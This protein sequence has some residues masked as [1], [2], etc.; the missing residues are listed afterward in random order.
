MP[1]Y[2]DKDFNPAQPV[3]NDGLV[4]WIAD[5]SEASLDLDSY[6][7]LAR[8][9]RAVLALELNA[10]S[11]LFEQWPQLSAEPKDLLTKV[12]LDPATRSALDSLFASPSNTRQPCIKLLQQFR[13]E[14]AKRINYAEVYRHLKGQQHPK[15]LEEC[16]RFQARIQEIRTATA[17]HTSEALRQLYRREYQRIEKERG[18]VMRG[19]H[20]IRYFDTTRQ[21][22]LTLLQVISPDAQPQSQLTDNDIQ[23]LLRQAL[24][25]SN[26]LL[27]NQIITAEKHYLLASETAQNLAAQLA[28]GQVADRPCFAVSWGDRA[29][30][31][32]A[33]GDVTYQEIN[34]HFRLS[35]N[36]TIVPPTEQSVEFNESNLDLHALNHC[37]RLRRLS[38]RGTYQNTDQDQQERLQLT[39]LERAALQPNSR[40]NRLTFKWFTEKAYALLRRVR[41]SVWPNNPPIEALNSVMENSLPNTTSLQ[42]GLENHEFLNILSDA[43]QQVIAQLIA[44]EKVYAENLPLQPATELQQKTAGILAFGEEALSLRNFIAVTDDN[45]AYITQTHGPI[46]LALINRHLFASDLSGHVFAKETLAGLRERTGT[47]NG[48]LNPITQN[49]LS[50]TPIG[51]RHLS[52]TKLNQLL[53]LRRLHEHSHLANSQ[54]R[55]MITTLPPFMQALLEMA[56]PNQLLKSSWFNPVA[57]TILQT[58]KPLNSLTP[59]NI[60]HL[61]NLIRQLN[62][63]PDEVL[64]NNI[65]LRQELTRLNLLPLQRQVIEQLLEAEKAYTVNLS[66]QSPQRISGILAFNQD[67]IWMRDFIAVTDKADEAD[68][69][70]PY[71]TKT[72]GDV[73]LQEINQCLFISGAGHVYSR[74][75]QENLPHQRQNRSVILDPQ[76]RQPLN[77]TDIN[78]Q[79]L[80]LAKL[81]QLLQLRRLHEQPTLNDTEILQT[82]NSLPAFMQDLLRTHTTLKASWF[83]GAAYIKLQSM[84]HLTLEQI[85]RMNAVPDQELS[86]ADSIE[87]ALARITSLEPPATTLSSEPPAVPEQIAPQMGAVPDQEL[88]NA[89]NGGQVLAPIPL[90]P[91]ALAADTAIT[92]LTDPIPV[93]VLSSAQQLAT[94]YQAFVQSLSPTKKTEAPVSTWDPTDD[95]TARHNRLAQCLAFCLNYLPQ[96]I[97]KREAYSDQTAIGGHFFARERF[98]KTTQQI[99]AAREKYDALYTVLTALIEQI[100]AELVP[101]SS[102]LNQGYTPVLT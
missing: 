43:K 18:R 65:A 59:E 74:Q 56:K 34:R 39:A 55:T 46:D 58:L 7:R 68:E 80:D 2:I 95:T 54:R 4:Q 98:G 6:Q 53:A 64:N 1:V 14:A 36:G 99:A 12:R 3:S 20:Q 67:P 9:L 76:T 85:E 52:L 31:F 30:V 100:N 19:M 29:V 77:A 40:L 72:R 82:I 8:L 41:E 87:Q 10:L 42:L 35:A 102:V 75:I 92:T 27:L 71:I 62:E 79:N 37:L 84:T 81:N 38:E 5:C 86:N 73:S 22:I 24:P 17:N 96:V 32:Q 25:P 57:Y 90:E 89:D 28:F 16:Q 11:R 13:L 97:R 44:A 49:P 50:V 83:T 26:Q 69:A 63:L 78:A 66:S 48:L 45:D 91:P 51:L 15:L 23:S 93:T 60:N 70:E 33:E 94:A 61:P 21:K 88:A 101:L 47:N